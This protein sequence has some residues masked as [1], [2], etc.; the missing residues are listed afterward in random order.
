MTKKPESM[1][2]IKT[3][4]PESAADPTKRLLERVKQ[5]MGTVPNI[6]ATMAHSLPVTNAFLEFNKSL[7]NGLL[8]PSLREKIS[9]AVAQAN[10]CGYG[11]AAHTAI[12]KKLGMSDAE[13]VDARVGKASDDRERAALEFSQRIVMK[14]G[15]VNDEDVVELRAAGYN[16]SEIAEIVGNVTLNIFTNYFNH[17][18]G[19]EVDFPAAVELTEAA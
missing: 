19:T 14:R 9:L 17:V 4:Q 2:R 13:T 1:Q 5:Q 15:A 10:D 12:G 7:A 8:S 3:V 11:L 16:D 18:A 6:I